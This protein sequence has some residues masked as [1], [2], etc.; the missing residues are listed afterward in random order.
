MPVTDHTRAT[1]DELCDAVRSVS[2]F[3]AVVALLQSQDG[4]ILEPAGWQLG[5]WVPGHAELTEPATGTSPGAK[6]LEMAITLVYSVDDNP[7]EEW[8]WPLRLTIQ[9]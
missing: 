1:A 7:P 3:S 8:D 6:A 9:R 2:G 5:N 4:V